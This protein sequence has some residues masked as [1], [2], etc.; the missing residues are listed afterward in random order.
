MWTV[1]LKQ[2]NFAIGIPERD[3]SLSKEEDPYRVRVS[4]GQLRGQRRGHPVLAHQVAHQR[5]WSNPTQLLVLFS[6][7]HDVQAYQPRRPNLVRFDRADLLTLDLQCNMV[8]KSPLSLHA[9]R[10]PT[11][12]YFL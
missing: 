3:Q 4:R 1:I 7:Q 11:F 9:S 12:W 5:A 6:G 2:A 10:P 8:S